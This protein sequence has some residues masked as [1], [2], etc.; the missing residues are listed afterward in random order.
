M[1]DDPAAQLASYRLQWQQVETA[2]VTEPDNKELKALKKD[3]EEVIELTKELV[4]PVTS[5]SSNGAASS[6]PMPAWQVC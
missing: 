6:L 3:L 5:S 4:Q 1:S 2:L